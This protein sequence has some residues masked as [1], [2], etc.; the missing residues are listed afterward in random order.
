M[1]VPIDLRLSN[2]D[3]PAP[4]P[5]RTI[6]TDL[7]N[8]PNPVKLGLLVR[9]FNYDDVTLYM[10]VD[11]YDSG[12]TFTT[13]NLGAC[14][15]GANFYT[16]FNDFG[17]RAKPSA[18]TEE[19][20]TVRLRAYTDS[21]YLNLKWTFERV[22]TVSFI[23]SDDGS[24][25][26]DFLN[27]FDDG[28]VQGWAVANESYNE[29]GF[30]QIA[31]VTDYVLSTPYAVKMTQ[32]ANSAHTVYSKGLYIRKDSDLLVK[33]G[34]GYNTALSDNQPANKWIRAVAP[35]PKN[36]TVQIQ[37]AHECLSYYSTGPYYYNL[38]GRFYKSFALPNKNK[39]FMI[40]D[41]R[42]YR[43]GAYGY[44]WMDDFK[45]ISKD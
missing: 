13:N 40:F 31:V 5:K 27:N 25:T 30:P 3:P 14:G 41:V 19:T 22:V 9:I 20:I 32:R 17:T 15:S 44:L 35:L 8:L 34:E 1:S 33:L 38:R 12:W 45:I 16:Y 37:I 18:E 24:W 2:V 26:V 23:K 29:G 4:E 10:K 11:G 42:P 43:G 6:Y 7:V 21:G 39:V 28:T 36:V